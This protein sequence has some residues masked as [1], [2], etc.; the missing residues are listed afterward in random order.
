MRAERLKQTLK[1]SVY[2]TIGET[3]AAVGA[4]GNGHR[5]LRV[6]MYH[7]VNNLPG[8]PLTMPV[9]LFD[10]QMHQLRELGYTVVGL[11]AVL[12]HYTD[13]KPL[14]PQAVL[15]TFDDGYHDNLDNAAEVLRRYGYPAVL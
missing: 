11:D 10:E 15:I 7:K 1:N 12:H 3:A 14:P 8:N 6:L 9:S 4:N 13:G 5:S 2:R